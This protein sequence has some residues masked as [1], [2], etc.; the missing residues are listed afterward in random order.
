MERK[1]RVLIA[2]PGLDG[3]DRGAK[4]VASALRDAGMEVGLGVDGSASNDT[5]NLI[6]EARLALLLTRV[7]EVDVKGMTAREALE[8]ATLGGA[9]CLGRDD[10]GAIVPQY[11]CDLALFDL[12]DTA[13]DKVGDRVAALLLCQPPPAK[14]V[15]IDGKIIDTE[16]P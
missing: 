3:H 2:K 7:R 14:V 10:I 6:Q 11:A 1:I 5:S 12:A 13:Y 8:M 4:I 9:C 15:V 16:F